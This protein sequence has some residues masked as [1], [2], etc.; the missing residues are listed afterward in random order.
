MWVVGLV[1]LTNLTAL[2]AFDKNVTGAL[3]LPLCGLLAVLYVG[4]KM[5]RK[6]LDQELEGI[7]NGAKNLLMLLVKII[8]PVS[9]FIV[10]MV[11]LFDRFLRT[12]FDGMSESAVK[13]FVEIRNISFMVIAVLVVMAVVLMVMS[14]SKKLAS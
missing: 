10:L 4:W 8:A 7:S 11:S 1:S 9:V 6:I 3:M 2:D 13:E 14:K 5:D 12:N